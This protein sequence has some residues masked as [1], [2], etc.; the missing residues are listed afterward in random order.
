MANINNILTPPRA[1]GGDLSANGRLFVNRGGIH[2]FYT[3][4]L[5]DLVGLGAFVTGDVKL[6]TLPA[7]A[8]MGPTL[9]RPTTAVTGVTTCTGQIKAITS[10]HTYGTAFNL[11]T[12]VSTTNVDL[13]DELQNE[14]AGGD[15]Y[16]HVITTVDNLSA[17]TAGEIDIYIDYTV[18]G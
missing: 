4:K 13:D 11:K 18:R 10:T 3:V 14:G 5:A 15:V 16:F 8:V 9:V 1:I 7:H 6:F 12:A 2:L 17:T